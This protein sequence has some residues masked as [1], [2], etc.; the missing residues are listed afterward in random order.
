MNELPLLT[1]LKAIYGVRMESFQT[2]FTGQNNNGD[3]V[4]KDEL[5]LDETDFLPSAALIY[6]HNEKMNIRFSFAKT[7][8][9]PSFKEKSLVQITDRLSNRV[10]IGNLD[11]ENT[12]I[13]NYDLR[14]EYFFGKAQMISLSGFYKLF[15]K[16]IETTVYDDLSPDNF[17]PR[18]VGDAEVLGIEL[19]VRKSLDFLSLPNLSVNGN[20]ALV[21]S[22]VK[23]TT[24]EYESRQA[25]LREGEQLSDSRDMAGQSPFLINAGLNYREPLS[26]WNVNVSFNMQG[27]KT[28]RG[29]CRQYSGRIRA[30]FRKF[31]FQSV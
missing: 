12:H 5:V 14:W 26:G 7:L 4:L 15:D 30:T 2:H 8:A 31:E 18:N 29:G 23:M 25:N 1:K 20:V 24:Q 9:R 11:L 16:P 10:F 22:S 19:E 6:S 28:L 3:L 21:H 27:G 17:T 13:A